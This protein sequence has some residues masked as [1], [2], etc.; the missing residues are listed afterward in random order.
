VTNESVAFFRRRTIS[1]ALVAF[2][3]S[4]AIVQALAKSDPG[5]TDW[6]RDLSSMSGARRKV[7]FMAHLPRIATA[8]TS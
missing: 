6:Q 1:N 8:R 5:N 7:T 2:R 3:D 4:F